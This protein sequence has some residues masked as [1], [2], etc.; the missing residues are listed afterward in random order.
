V[1]VIP[2]FFSFFSFVFIH[3]L[4]SVMITDPPLLYLPSLS[5]LS[6]LS[7]SLFRLIFFLFSSFL[8]FLSV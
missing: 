3:L 8:I 7:F 5:S 2:F 6:S 4:L 1:D